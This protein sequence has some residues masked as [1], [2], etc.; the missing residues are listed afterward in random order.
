MDKGIIY[1]D[2]HLLMHQVIVNE[3]F[4]FVKKMLILLPLKA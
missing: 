4:L 3:R 2:S 1:F